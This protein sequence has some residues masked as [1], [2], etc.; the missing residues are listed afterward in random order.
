M[1]A[2]DSRSITHFSVDEIAPHHDHL[3]AIYDVARQ[4]AVRICLARSIRVPFNP[5]ESR[6][7]QDV[8]IIETREELALLIKGL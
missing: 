1:L 4:R 7:C 6:H 2:L 3:R 5:F 8:N